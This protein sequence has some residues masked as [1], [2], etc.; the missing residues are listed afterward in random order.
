[1]VV[2]ALVHP[3]DLQDR[4]SAPQR[5]LTVADTLPRLELIRAD[6][7]SVGPLQIWV[8]ATLGWRLQ[9]V[10]RPGGRGRWL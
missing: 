6:S 9:L 10:E 8:W 2:K 5:L 1:L 3:A 7:A 4:V